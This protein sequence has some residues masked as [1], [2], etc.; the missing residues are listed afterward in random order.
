[1]YTNIVNQFLSKVQIQLSGEM[2]DSSKN[3]GGKIEHPYAKI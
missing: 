3:Y 2:I 1:M